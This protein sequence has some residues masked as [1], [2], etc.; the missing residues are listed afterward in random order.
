MLFDPLGEIESSLMQWF[1]TFLAPGTGFVEDNFSM[2]PAWGGVGGDGS[3]GNMSDGG[4][5][6][7]QM[8]L[9][10]LARRSPPAVWPRGW[11]PLL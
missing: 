5:R 10:S 7:R 11:G 9:R 6:K 4:D 1:P 2:D 3:G 8:Q